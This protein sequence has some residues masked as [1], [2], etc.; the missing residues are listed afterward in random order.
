MITNANIKPIVMILRERFGLI[1]LISIIYALVYIHIVGIILYLPSPLE[2]VNST[3]FIR[4]TSYGIVF[5]PTKTIY[6]FAFWH[7]IAFII[8]T[9]LLV[10]INIALILRY[11]WLIKSCCRVDHHYYYNNNKKKS[12]NSNQKEDNSIKGIPSVIASMIPAFFTSFS[13]CGGGL[14][15]LAIGPIAFSYLTIYGMYIAL[16]TIAMLLTSTYMLSRSI[17]MVIKNASA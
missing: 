12:R 11:R 16:L 1:L 9:S 3:P 5:M 6:M 15:A 17:S 8:V 7:A 4:V 10:S 14:L 2:F 13:C